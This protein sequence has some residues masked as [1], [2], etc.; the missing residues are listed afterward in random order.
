MTAPTLEREVTRA[1][2]DAIFTSLRATALAELTAVK[3]DLP[4]LDV[5]VD[6]AVASGVAFLNE[7]YGR[8]DWLQRVDLDTLDVRTQLNCVLAQ[9][10][11][12]TYTE[13]LDAVGAP[14]GLS[15]ERTRWTDA[16]GFSR[17]LADCGNW[18]SCVRY[19]QLTRAWVAK[20]SELRAEAT[21]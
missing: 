8:D 3:T 20:I 14:V 6:V 15:S 4:S 11:G 10:T 19:E 9:V 12:R 21:S 13:A 5:P 18:E 16:H 2:T 1:E 17:D 7:R